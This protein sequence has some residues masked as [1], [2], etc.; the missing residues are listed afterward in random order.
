ML[1]AGIDWSEKFLDFHL[2]KGDGEVLAQ[3]R[4]HP[5]VD[6]M[7]SLFVEFESHA[8]ASEIGV[9]IGLPTGPGCRLCWIAAT[10]CIR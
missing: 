9:A 1:F 5:N 4:V 2:R 7:A 10:R 8:V 6:G 3:G